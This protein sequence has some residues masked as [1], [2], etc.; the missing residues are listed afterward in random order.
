VPPRQAERPPGWLARDERTHAI[1]ELE[2]IVAY[3]LYGLDRDELAHILDTFPVVRRREEQEF[4]AYLSKQRALA[5]H[6]AERSAGPPALPTV[7]A[8]FPARAVAT[9]APRRAA[10]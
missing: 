6:D 10:R 7:A 2:A 1:A 5:A 9:A 8:E 3:H 4:G